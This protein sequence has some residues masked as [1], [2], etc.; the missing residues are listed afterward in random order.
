MAIT[1]KTKTQAQAS[2]QTTFNGKVVTE[3]DM[4]KTYRVQMYSGFNH[5]TS[6]EL[7]KVLTS[8][9][10][11]L[12]TK[13]ENKLGQVA[14][15]IEVEKDDNVYAL[16]NISFYE[17]SLGD[18]STA[19]EQKEVTETFLAEIKEAGTVSIS[20]LLTEEEGKT[21]LESLLA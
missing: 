18:N 14:F 13:P 21:V 7:Y 17:N 10:V 5:I 1:E 6:E 16:G 19:P 11:S 20:K 2:N 9:K 15:T 8:K 3:A 4:V 12:C